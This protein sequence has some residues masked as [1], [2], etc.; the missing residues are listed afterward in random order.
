MGAG[1]WNDGMNRV[2]AQGKGESV[3]LGMFMCEV[4][5]EFAPYSG[6]ADAL[7]AR[8][9]ELIA[10]L[11]QH[12]WDGH[13]YR[14]AYYDDGRPLGSAQGE[15]CRIDLLSQAWAALAGLDER[16]VSSALEAAWELLVD[17]DAGI[18]RL[19]TPPFDDGAEQPGYI[20]GYLPG[21][22]ENG[23]QYTHAAVWLMLALMRTGQRRRA[24][25]VLEMLLPPGHADSRA[26]AGRYRVEP[27]VLAADIYGAPPYE[28]RGGWTWY[29]GSA[30]WLTYAVRE[31]ML[32]L[33]VRAGRLRFAPRVP[34]YWQ[35]VRVSY[36]WG[37]ARYEITARRSCRSAT[38]PEAVR[39]GWIELKD[40]GAVHEITL[41]LR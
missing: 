6:R 9:S 23:G 5:R 20:K 13:W 40:D 32:G 37:S 29:T 2:G 16:R 25:Q 8:R 22:R 7:L 21:I 18:V 34:E 28:G 4:L 24:W 10:A 12:G 31:H 36:A 27:Y 35:E 17:T 33:T 38:P 3:W 39:G 14:R 30:A 15:E 26:A 11:E 1:D 41:P 19:L